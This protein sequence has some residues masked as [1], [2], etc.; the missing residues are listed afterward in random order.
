MWR[1]EISFAF[2][3]TIFTISVNFPHFLN[4]GNALA[5]IVRNQDKGG[6]L[7]SGDD[8]GEF[9]NLCKLLKFKEF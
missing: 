6:P 3:S 7:V 2:T 9:H 8:S 5:S 1:L 4:Q